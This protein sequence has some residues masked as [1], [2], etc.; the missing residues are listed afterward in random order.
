M[1]AMI[2]NFLAFQ[3]GW[4]ACV[5]GGA[6]G[7]RL[8]AVRFADPLLSLGVLSVGWALLMPLLLWVADRW[9]GW[10]EPIPDPR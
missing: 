2:I 8:G 5:L 3:A 10:A 6:S 4:F 1:Q 7:S 9:D